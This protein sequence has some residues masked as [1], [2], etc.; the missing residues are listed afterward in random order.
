MTY[1]Q[2]C[3]TLEELKK[4]YFKC[5]KLLHPDNNGDL[6]NFQNMQSE[7]VEVFEKLKNIHK[8][9]Y[10]ETYYKEN[11]EGPGDYKNIIDKIINYDGIKIEICGKWVWVYGDTKKYKNDFKALGFK[12]AHNKGAWYWFSGKYRKA[13]KYEW[14]FTEIRN[15]FGSELVQSDN[16]ILEKKIL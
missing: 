6:S 13:T 16:H 3:L 11:E 9:R 12:W 14:T 5:V 8:N 15:A 10:D 7:Y 2:N 4:E 1:F